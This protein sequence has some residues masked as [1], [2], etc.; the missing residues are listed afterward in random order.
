MF[1]P[2]RIKA[3]ILP[4]P[5]KLDVSHSGKYNVT[6]DAIIPS[7]YPDR[8]SRRVRYKTHKGILIKFTDIHYVPPCG[9]LQRDSARSV[10]N[11]MVIILMT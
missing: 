2:Q 4:P 5:N 10:L 11:Q 3:I 9:P 8:S 1:S 6:F 7:L